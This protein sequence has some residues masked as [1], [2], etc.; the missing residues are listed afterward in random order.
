MTVWGFKFNFLQTE[1]VHSAKPI[2]SQPIPN[3]KTN[4]NSI[5][6]SVPKSKA[7]PNPN[8]QAS[9][10]VSV[11]IAKSKQTHSN[12]NGSKSSRSHP[13]VEEDVDVDPRE[14]NPHVDLNLLRQPVNKL[15]K[16]LLD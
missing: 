9:D 4:P 11:P 12:A 7:I 14:Q 2:G 3:S 6:K 10:P 8:Q 16:N 13:R 1:T 5:P 15:G